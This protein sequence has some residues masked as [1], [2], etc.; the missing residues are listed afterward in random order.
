MKYISHRKVV[1]VSLSGRSVSFAK[2]VPTYAP[3]QMHDEL[4]TMG[5]MPEGGLVEP[6]EKEKTAE[7]TMAADR[8]AA[9]MAQFDKMVQRGRREDFTAVG[10]PH[11]SVVARELGWA[12]MVAKERDAMW[13]KWMQAQLEKEEN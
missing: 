2:G 11:L 12:N 8:E 9:L 7:P 1:V 3:P 5:I 6:E 4:I 10:A 13:D